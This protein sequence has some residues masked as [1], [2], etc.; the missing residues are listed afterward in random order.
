MSK[1]RIAVEWGFGGIARFWP[2]L[3]MRL[4]QKLY[5]SPLETALL[6]SETLFLIGNFA[7]VQLMSNAMALLKVR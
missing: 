2:C 6:Q 1:V 4:S 3:D 7:L 5:L